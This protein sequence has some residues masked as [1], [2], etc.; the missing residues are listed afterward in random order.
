[1]I[2]LLNRLQQVF[3]EDK[4]IQPSELDVV[5]QALVKELASIVRKLDRIKAQLETLRQQK[6]ELEPEIIKK[7]EELEKQGVRVGKILLYVRTQKQIPSFK[8]VYEK[9]RAELSPEV[10][11]LLEETYKQLTK[12]LG[13]A[14]SYKVE[15]VQEDW[16]DWLMKLKDFFRRIFDPLLKRI[17]GTIGSIES[18]LGIKK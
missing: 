14:I 6:K 10:Q 17:S 1:M 11:K 7:L 16:R 15:S 18:L 12:E 8:R 9:V 5:H 3:E 13:K 2:D 4:Y